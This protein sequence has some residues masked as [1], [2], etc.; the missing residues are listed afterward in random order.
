MRKIRKHITVGISLCFALTFFSSCT[1]EGTEKESV[2]EVV[3]EVSIK[4]VPDVDYA[5]EDVMLN[6]QNG[7]WMSKTDSSLI[8]GYI[9]MKLSN[10]SLVSRFGVVEGKKEGMSTV[11]FPSGKL[12]FLENYR[13]N[14]LH[15]EVKR[16]T[17]E[18]GYQLVALLNYKK[19][20]LDGEQKKWYNTGEL[21]KILHVNMGVE[22]GIQ[23]AFRKNGKLYANYEA[24][25]GKH[26]G[27]KRSM[28]CVELND[29]N[30]VSNE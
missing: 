28:L 1:Q 6:K 3:E 16:W 4:T 27:M 12:R 24:R 8:S 18:F 13:N 10:D 30:V 2:P 21:F 14:K 17:E 11:Y 26:Y 22:E 29:E 7:L 20:K 25:D 5:I 23:Q 19:G 15:G 9:V